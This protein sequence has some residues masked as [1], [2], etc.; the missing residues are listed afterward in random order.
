MRKTNV[1]YTA[2]L[3]LAASCSTIAPVPN[4]SIRYVSYTDS[5]AKFGVAEQEVHSIGTPATAYFFYRKNAIHANEG[6]IDGYPLHGNYLVYNSSNSLI[7]KGQ[8]KKGVRIGTW[9][10]W[11]AGGKLT[12]MV[13]YS[14]GK[15]VKVVLPKPVKAKKQKVSA[16]VTADTSKRK[17]YQIFRKRS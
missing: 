16:K 17:W 9:M 15:L 12:S 13:K 6:A 3:L 14:N 1:T 11:D 10:R 8:F 4:S 7:C 5:S 2:I